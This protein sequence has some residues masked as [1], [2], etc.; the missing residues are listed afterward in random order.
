MTKLSTMFYNTAQN[1]FQWQ[2]IRHCWTITS[3]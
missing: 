3:A 1:Q 2:S